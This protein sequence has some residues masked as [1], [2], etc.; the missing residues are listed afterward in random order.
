MRKERVINRKED[1][2]VSVYLD[3]EIKN[4]FE[5][6]IS[7][8]AERKKISKNELITYA[9]LKGIL[10]VLD[11]EDI[12]NEYFKDLDNCLS[13]IRNSQRSKYRV[14][15]NLTIDKGTWENIYNIIKSKKSSLTD[16]LINPEKE[17]EKFEDVKEKLIEFLKNKIKVENKELIF[18]KQVKL[19]KEEKKRKIE[20]NE[21][22]LK[23][24]LTLSKTSYQYSSIVLR[25]KDMIIEIVEKF[26]IK[27]SNHNNIQIEIKNIDRDLPKEFLK[28]SYIVL[29]Q[30][31]DKE[32][33]D[34]QD[35]K[36]KYLLTKMSILDLIYDV[37][38]EIFEGDKEKIKKFISRFY[39][40]Y[41]VSN[42]LE[43]ED[44]PIIKKAKLEKELNIYRGFFEYYLWNKL[45]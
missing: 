42:L 9:I 20:I 29:S 23:Y 7:E 32:I 22:E 14:R 2:R 6:C 11:L 24:I 34:L 10:K 37:I 30:N 1:V 12:E 27:Y 5:K 16:I 43:Y 38:Y 44:I 31:K 36:N 13:L 3:R 40:Y 26:K 17:K 41:V 15:Y 39:N 8:L 21:K 18:K 4:K 28:V 35:F 25:V 33:K 19:K 45:I